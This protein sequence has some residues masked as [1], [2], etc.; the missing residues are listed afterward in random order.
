MESHSPF[1][2]AIAA[3][4]EER[5][6]NALELFLVC[7]EDPEYDKAELLFHC[8]WCT[9]QSKGGDMGRALCYYEQATF[10]AASPSCKLNSFFRAGW[11]LTQQNL[12]NKAATIFRRAIDFADVCHQKDETYSETVFWYAVCLESLGQYI[13]AIKWYRL[14]KTLSS[15]LDPE[16]RLRELSCLNNIGSYDEA[17]KVYSTFDAPA[18]RGFGETRYFELQKNVERE[19]AMLHDVLSTTP[20]YLGAG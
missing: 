6:A 11:L 9:E 18:P 8:G 19:R 15:R 1:E 4:H 10:E 3:E 17:M 14:A 5:F 20:S 2:R 12:H 7:M 16:S 13:D